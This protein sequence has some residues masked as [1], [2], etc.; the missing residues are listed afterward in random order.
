MEYSFAKTDA[1][2]LPLCALYVEWV[3]TQHVMSQMEGYRVATYIVLEYLRSSNSTPGARCP[4]I[5]QNLFVRYGGEREGADPY[6]LTQLASN[7]E[8]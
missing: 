2:V 3:L 4:V 1:L 6:W 7:T 8:R 5:L